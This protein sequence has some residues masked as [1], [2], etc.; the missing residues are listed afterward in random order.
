MDRC[1]D[2][3]EDQLADRTDQPV[4]VLP[5]ESVASAHAFDRGQDPLEHPVLAGGR[6]EQEAS[7]D[8]SAGHLDR[9]VVDFED[10]ADLSELEV[11]EASADARLRVF[12]LS[13]LPEV[14]ELRVEGCQ[15]A[16]AGLRPAASFDEGGLGDPDAQ[17]EQAVRAD[18]PCQAS[19]DAQAGRANLQVQVVEVGVDVVAPHLREVAAA[20]VVHP[21]QASADASAEVHSVPQAQDPGASAGR[22]A[23]AHLEQKRPRTPPKLNL[24]LDAAADHEQ[25]VAVAY[26]AAG[27]DG[28]SERHG[29][30][31]GALPGA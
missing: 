7:A 29:Q 8:A 25:A 28:E 3:L 2:A 15:R 22:D 14:C 20:D 6:L 18:R 16:P 17:V 31:L 10:R 1:N 27:A 21:V 4:W 13:E 24:G 11:F 23:Q 26:V 5:E 9:W 30:P 19:A 12:R